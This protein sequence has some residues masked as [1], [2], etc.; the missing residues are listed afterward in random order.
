MKEA[1]EVP[2]AS[3]DRIDASETLLHYLRKNGDSSVKLGCEEGHCGACMV[4]LDGAPRY[5]CL[6]LS[7]RSPVEVETAGTLAGTEAGAQVAQ[8][9]ADAGA[10]QCGYCTPGVLVTLT[11]LLRQGTLEDTSVKEALEAHHCRCTGYYGFLRATTLLRQRNEGKA[12]E[13]T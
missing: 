2:G 6:N 1:L 9:L 13:S 8:A 7:Q 4:L 10:V 3:S 12:V 5:A 11:Y